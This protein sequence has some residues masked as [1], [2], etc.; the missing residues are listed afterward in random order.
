MQ[1]SISLAPRTGQ[2]QSS[3]VTDPIIDFKDTVVQG[4]VFEKLRTENSSTA[5]K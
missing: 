3:E 1:A 2:Q 5:G 4:K